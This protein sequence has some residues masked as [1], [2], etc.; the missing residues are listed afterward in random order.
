MAGW[1]LVRIAWSVAGGVLTQGGMFFTSVAL[2]RIL[3]KHEFGRFAMIQSTAITLSALA[4]LLVYAL[5]ELLPY[6]RKGIPF[7]I[8]PL[9][10]SLSKNLR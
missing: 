1:A 7:H 4:S 10:L 5:H 9:D 2:A 6:C 3:G 8:S